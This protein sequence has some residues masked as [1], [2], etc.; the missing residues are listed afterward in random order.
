MNPPLKPQ[1][2]PLGRG[3]LT[4]ARTPPQVWG[5]VADGKCFCASDSKSWGIQTS[6]NIPARSEKAG[7]HCYMGRKDVPSCVPSSTESSEFT[8]SKCL[9]TAACKSVGDADS[10][11]QLIRSV[12]GHIRSA[13]RK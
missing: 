6:F 2:V 11:G 13:F 10:R 4:A 9:D 12:R 8:L 7:V 3:P 1:S 5:E